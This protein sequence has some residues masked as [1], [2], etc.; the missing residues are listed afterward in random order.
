MGPA[1]IADAAFA[2][3]LRQ[4]TDHAGGRRLGER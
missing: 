2:R 4:A 1:V 3:Y